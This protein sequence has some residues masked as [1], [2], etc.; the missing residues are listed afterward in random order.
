MATPLPP[1][2]PMPPPHT[3]ALADASLLAFVR[4]MGRGHDMALPPPPTLLG[5]RAKCLDRGRWRISAGRRITLASGVALAPQP[6]E[7]S[8]PP[9]TVECWLGLQS[10]PV[11]NIAAWSVAPTGGLVLCCIDAVRVRADGRLP[12]ARRLAS[13]SAEVCGGGMGDGGGSGV[14]MAPSVADYYVGKSVLITGG[15]GFMGKV[16]VE[17]LLRSCPGVKALY[18]LVRPKASQTMQQRVSDMMKCKRRA[19]ECVSVGG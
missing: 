3:S 10:G 19:S 13:A 14:A 17:K 15:T 9:I 1:P 7:D 6:R 8:L 12:N 5:F 18:L 2:S 11:A 16:L 4:L